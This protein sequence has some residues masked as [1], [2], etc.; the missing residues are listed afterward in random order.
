MKNKIVI[1]CF[2]L[3]GFQA[4]Q[5]G[6]DYKSVR[7]EVL[8]AHDKVMM[9]GETAIKNKMSLDTILANLDSLRTAKII[10]D[11]TVERQAIG[12]LQSKLN[13]ADEQMNDW[14]HEFNAEL[15]GKSNEEAVIY[16]KAEQ[17]KVKRL[18]S[19]YRAAI[20]ES[21]AFIKRIKK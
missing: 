16:F 5:N 21:D 6:S 19:V 10:S 3:L 18:D 17:E 1:L 15:D 4:C 2:L 20:G 7:K 14:M 12:K 13:A 9:D 11:T 8:D